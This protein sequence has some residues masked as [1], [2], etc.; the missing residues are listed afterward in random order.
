MEPPASVSVNQF[1]DRRDAAEEDEQINLQLDSQNRIHALPPEHL[2]D[3][4]FLTRES[5][6]FTDGKGTL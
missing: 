2:Q 1:S 3:A 4:Y 5:V 6:A